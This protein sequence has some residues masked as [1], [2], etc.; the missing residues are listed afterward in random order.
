MLASKEQSWMKLDYCCLIRAYVV[1]EDVYRSYKQHMLLLDN[2]NPIS[3]MTV[4]YSPTSI[5][6]SLSF[7]T[8]A[9]GSEWHK[10]AH[11][12]YNAN[13]TVFFVQG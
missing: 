6:Q 13:N 9:N 7:S 12:E 8:V 3:S 10:M 2:N 1:S 4:P 5:T 11:Q